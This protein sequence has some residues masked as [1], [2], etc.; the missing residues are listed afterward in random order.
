MG[1]YVKKLVPCLQ[2]G[3]RKPIRNIVR[4]GAGVVWMQGGDACVALPA[5]IYAGWG[6]L[7]RPACPH[8]CRAGTLASPC[9][10]ASMQGGDACVALPARIYVGWGRLRRPA[11]P[12][13]CKTQLVALA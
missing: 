5:R 8:L 7:R 3:L 2:K 4:V 9:L 6:R 12:H 11:C 10:P 1:T 13:R